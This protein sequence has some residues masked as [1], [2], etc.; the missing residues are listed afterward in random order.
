MRKR[1][2]AS[3]TIKSVAHALAVLEELGKEGDELGV[4][5]LSRRLNLHKNNIFRLLATLETWGYVEQNK[6]TENYRLGLKIVELAQNY[7]K[8][9]NLLKQIRPILEEIVQKTNENVGLAVLRDQWIVYLDVIEA[10]QLVKVACRAG[11]RIP[12]YA[13]ASGKVQLAYKSQSEVEKL[14]DWKNLK[15]FTPNTITDKEAFLRH[16]QEVRE[17][18]YAI[19][20]EEYEEGVKCV[21]VPVRDYTKRVV[22]AIS[23][24]APSFRLSDERIEK[25]IVPLLKEMGLKASQRLGYTGV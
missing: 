21:A 4:S 13:S 15:A 8:Q 18:G 16:L 11:W 6:E 17:K 12:A 20:N 9:S 2:K 22:A 7:L 3:Y 14:I 1:E 19:D 10:D 5:E 24:Q 25:E 23:L